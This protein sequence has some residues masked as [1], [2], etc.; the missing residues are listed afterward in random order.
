MGLFAT[1]QATSSSSGASTSSS[2]SV[3][4]LVQLFVDRPLR[5]SDAHSDD[6]AGGDGNHG[7]K[8]S[9]WDLLKQGPGV[10]PAWKLASL[11]QVPTWACLSYQTTQV[12]ETSSSQTN[13]DLGIWNC[14]VSTDKEGKSGVTDALLKIPPAECQK[15]CLTL[16]LSEVNNNNDNN[17]A[18]KI[19]PRLTKMQQALVRFLIARG[20]VNATKPKDAQDEPVATIT[21][22]EE[23][24][25]E[26]KTNDDDDHDDDDDELETKDNETTSLFKL[27]TVQFGLAKEGEQPKSSSSAEDERAD[28]DYKIALMICVILPS[29]KAKSDNQDSQD[30]DDGDDNNEDSYH[31][32]QTLQLFYYHL[33]KY[34]YE[35]N[36]ALIFVDPKMSSDAK[37]SAAETVRACSLSQLALL[38]RAYCLGQPIW[39]AYPQILELPQPLDNDGANKEEAGEETK[40][41]QEE[42][43]R[44]PNEEPNSNT[45]SFVYGPSTYQEDLLDSVVL[46]NAQ[47]PGYWDASKESLWTILPDMTLQTRQKESKEE[48]TKASS[49]SP[50]GIGDL[51]WLIE[52]KESMDA[53]AGTD[54]APAEET[55]TGLTADELMATIGGSPAASNKKV[56]K[57]PATQA[58]KTKKE[59]AATPGDAAAFFESL[60]K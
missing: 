53:I 38:W 20:N 40:E 21:T 35:L 18:S 51:S 49:T 23:T 54:T 33:R 28:Q 11:C 58:S 19:E 30:D 10:K 50:P 56:P 55:K 5:C 14:R 25:G 3:P 27:R 13:V 36:C 17:N 31:A 60:L 41:S 48:D 1:L 45:T 42:A 22:S 39:S 26:A 29:Q 8:Q 9:K 37:S 12:F 16:D 44:D 24:E 15:F 43:N 57:T 47:Y 52:L 32:K 46:R 7:N 6:G 34:A 4:T 59:A 2:L